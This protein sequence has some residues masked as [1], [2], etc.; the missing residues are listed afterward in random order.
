[1][2]TFVYKVDSGKGT[3]SL[4]LYPMDMSKVV[5]Q[6]SY[7]SYYQDSKEGELVED[8]TL[9]EQGVMKSTKDIDGLKKHLVSIEVIKPEDEIIQS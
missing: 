1:M 3:L 8:L 7:P 9:I 4:S 6:H 2:A 5:W